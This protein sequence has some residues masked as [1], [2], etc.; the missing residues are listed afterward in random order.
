LGFAT[1]IKL[2]GSIVGNACIIVKG[3]C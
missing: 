3:L 1:I 2:A